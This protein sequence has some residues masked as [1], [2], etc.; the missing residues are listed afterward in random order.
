MSSRREISN[1][2]SHREISNKR[3]RR[4]CIDCPI[5][6]PEQLGTAILVAAVVFP[7]GTTEAFYRCPQCGWMLMIMGVYGSP[8][9]HER[10]IWSEEE[11]TKM[12]VERARAAEIEY[13]HPDWEKRVI[14]ELA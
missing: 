7:T 12:L 4:D 3:S 11:L 9:R 2:S 8:F 6:S 10:K 14:L 1:R 13:M 5:C